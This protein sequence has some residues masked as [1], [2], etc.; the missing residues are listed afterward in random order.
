VT[1][2][3]PCQ[4]SFDCAENEFCEPTLGLCLP[5]PPGGPDCEH[6]PPVPSFEP[7]IEWSWTN[8]VIKPNYD[9]LLSV[10]LV[11]DGDK[12]GT[13][14]M[15]IVT[16]YTGDGGCNTGHA[17]L[18]ALD[19]KTGLEKWGAGVD[20]YTD[21]ARIALCRTP[22]LGDIDGDGFIEIV[23]HRFGGG[24][25]AFN[26][27]G[28]TLW[29]SKMKDGVT[30]YNGAFGWSAT[31]SIANMDK[32]I[33]PEI[34]SGGVI[35]DSTGKLIAG[36]GKECAGSNGGCGGNTIV[37]DVD[38]DGTHEVLAGNV[39]YKLDGTAKWTNGMADGY[40]A[41]A[42]FNGDGDPELVVISAG[43]A[44]V[45]DAKS[46]A[47]LVAFDMPGVGAGGPPTID[48]FNDDKVLDFASAVGDSYT[49][50]DFTMNPPKIGVKWSVATAD[51]SSSR[52]GSSL[53]DFEGDG[54]AEILYNDECFLRVYDGKSGNVLF[55][56]PSNSG[57]AALYPVAVDV[58][59][60]NNTELVVVN[61]DWY[62]LS[63]ITPD[64]FAEY[65]GMANHRHGVFVYGDKNDKWVRTR[66]I[67]NQ[68]AYHISNVNGDGS[69][70]QPEQASWLTPT[71]NK[72][73]V[74]A[75]GSGVFNAPDLKVDVAALTT[76][77][78]AALLVRA[79]VRNEGSLGVGPGVKVQFYYGVDQGG[80]LLGEAATTKPLLPGQSEAVDFEA[81]LAGKSTPHAFFVTVD[82]SAPGDVEE[83]LEDNNTASVG[84]LD[85]PMLN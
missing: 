15:Y 72:Y 53:F 45:H 18:R 16:H 3:T 74:S 5:Q 77:C 29:T 12:D 76:P 62:Q 48:D 26:H 61:D 23:A 41:I 50:F 21:A 44:R 55:E 19:G 9:Q 22:A 24:L 40:P 78:P 39:A 8:S 28:S 32:D 2:T 85:C 79:T 67:W 11:A 35:L 66:R 4:D 73:R 36:S 27:D 80:D 34:V 52:T 43:T 1:P 47:L 63:N 38:N 82:G 75:Q 33:K 64:C 51:A 69:I 37:A 25:I 71:T 65:G 13:P 20:A 83:C 31:V 30:P 56:T 54:A 14:D 57:T 6:K 46:G 84:D 60:D 49:V 70:P 17:Y 7:V 68:H 58:D 81:S 42:D 10:P 59:G